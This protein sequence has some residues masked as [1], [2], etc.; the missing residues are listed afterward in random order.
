[1]K[2]LNEKNY[3]Y[4]IGF[5]LNRNMFFPKKSYSQLWYITNGLSTD[6]VA[7]GVDVDNAGIFIGL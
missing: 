4:I 5:D 2:R 1:M 6:E 3:F 7:W